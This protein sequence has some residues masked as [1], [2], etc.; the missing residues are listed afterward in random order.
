MD[1]IK[2]ETVIEIIKWAEEQ[3]HIKGD[4][5]LVIKTIYNY[6]EG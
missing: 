1:T 2:I 5:D 4:I 3:G 6:N